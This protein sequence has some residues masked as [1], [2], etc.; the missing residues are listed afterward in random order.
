MEDMPDVVYALINTTD[1]DGTLYAIPY[2]IKNDQVIEKTKKEDITVS[3]AGAWNIRCG[4]ERCSTLP[5]Q[6]ILGY[7]GEDD[8]MVNCGKTHSSTVLMTPKR[9]I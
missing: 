2:R 5:R 8:Q 3:L 7:D 9:L 4:L 6:R 1:S